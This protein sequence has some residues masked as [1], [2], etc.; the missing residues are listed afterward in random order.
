MVDDRGIV[1]VDRPDMTAC[2]ATEIV[3][4][5]AEP[6]KPLRF[7]RIAAHSTRLASHAADWLHCWCQVD[8]PRLLT[9]RARQSGAVGVQRNSYLAV[10]RFPQ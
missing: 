5:G 2:L 9:R 7:S 6:V 10:V 3:D 8:H 4:Y 1:L